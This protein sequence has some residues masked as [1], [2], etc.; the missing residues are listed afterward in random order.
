MHT[1]NAKM[2]Y[3]HTIQFSAQYMNI[4]LIFLWLRFYALC[5]SSFG[6][7]AVCESVAIPGKCFEAK[8]YQTVFLL[9]LLQEYWGLVLSNNKNCCRSFHILRQHL[10]MKLCQRTLIFKK[11]ISQML[12]KICC[13]MELKTA[14][15]WGGGGV[16]CSNSKKHPFWLGL[17]ISLGHVKTY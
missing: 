9:Q 6:E 15:G 11:G 8:P 7:R 2:I 10:I 1:R 12:P 16:V 4:I 5:M 3:N 13:M 14:G 17:S